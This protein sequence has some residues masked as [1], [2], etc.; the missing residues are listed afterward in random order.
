MIEG[1]ENN[2][3]DAKYIKDKP[4]KEEPSTILGNASLVVGIL[5]LVLFLMPYFALPLAIMG[6]V[7]SSKQNKKHKTSNS[8]AGLILSIIGVVIGTSLGLVMLVFTVILGKV[9]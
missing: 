1:D 2:M 9:L 3:K 5:S 6:I 7:L 4:N 8:T